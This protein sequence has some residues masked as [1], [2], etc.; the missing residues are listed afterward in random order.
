MGLYS[1]NTVSAVT[2]RPQFC[3]G[4]LLSERQRLSWK[5]S[6]YGRHLSSLSTAAE[7]LQFLLGYYVITGFFTL[8]TK[9]AITS[10]GLL[11]CSILRQSMTNVAF[12][13]NKPFLT[14]CIFPHCSTVWNLNA[15]FCL[16]ML[17]RNLQNL[18]RAIYVIYISETPQII[19][20]TLVI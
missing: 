4:L 17:P 6:N 8:L 5:R 12:R 15:V 16:N 13:C 10:C 14:K 7:W 2:K 19:S 20:H 9:P 1:V 3:Y 18:L 11:S